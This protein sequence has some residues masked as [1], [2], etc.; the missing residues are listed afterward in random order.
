M[1]KFPEIHTPVKAGYI[2]NMGDRKLEVIEVLGH[3]TCSPVPYNKSEFTD[4]A[5]LCRYQ[6]A[7][8]AYDPNNLHISN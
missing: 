7:E 1:S 8:V 2:F 5:L 3:T 6:T 4:G